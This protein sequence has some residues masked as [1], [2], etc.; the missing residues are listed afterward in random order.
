MYRSNATFFCV[1]NMKL[2]LLLWT[3]TSFLFYFLS[4]RKLYIFEVMFILEIPQYIHNMSDY[5]H[6]LA[7][8]KTK[9]FV[10][11][12]VKTFGTWLKFL[13]NKYFIKA[14]NQILQKLEIFY[15]AYV[16]IPKELRQCCI[17]N[18]RVKLPL[19]LLSLPRLIYISLLQ[20]FC[21][22]FLYP[23]PK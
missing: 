1:C 7:V 6:H 16:W 5:M 10:V 22:P 14:H 11:P 9:R 3:S 2:F 21:L 20:M 23:Y 12:Y 13:Y 8:L 15:M 18:K 17:V 19:L 4:D